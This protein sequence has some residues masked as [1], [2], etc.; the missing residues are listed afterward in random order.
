MPGNGSL[1]SRS[2]SAAFNGASFSASAR[3][4][5]SVPDLQSAPLGDARCVR[6]GELLG[7]RGVREPRWADAGLRSGVRRRPARRCSVSVEYVLNLDVGF[8]PL[9]QTTRSRSSAVRIRFVDFEPL[10]RQRAA[11]VDGQSAVFLLRRLVERVADAGTYPGGR[12][13]RLHAQVLGAARPAR[14]GRM[15]CSMRPPSWSASCSVRLGCVFPLPARRPV[16]A[17]VA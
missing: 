7:A 14:S 12:R 2:C 10:G 13:L 11:L 15:Y 9:P 1:H 4:S 17:A 16:L 3:C 8:R 6:E 5:T